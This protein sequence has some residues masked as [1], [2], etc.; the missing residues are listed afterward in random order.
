MTDAPHVRVAILGGGMAGLC[1]AIR[2]KQRGV[3]S[4]ALLEKAGRVGGTWRENTYPGVACDVPSHLYSF[5]FEQNPEWSRVFAPGWE[6]QKYCERCVETYGLASHLRLGTEVRDVRFEDGRW[7]VETSDG[8]TLFADCVVSALGGLHRP[9]R[10]SFPGQASFRGRLFHSAEWDHACDMR[11]KRVGVVGSGASAIQIVPAIAPDTAEVKQFQRTPGWVVPR[12]DSAIS[13]ATRRRFRDHPWLLRAQR[14]LLY[15]LLEARGRFVVEGSWMNRLVEKQARGH[16]AKQ[17]RDPDTRRSLTPDY[18]LGCKRVLVSDDYY[19]S[20]N[21]DN[22][23]LVTS[24]IEGFEPEG[25]RSADGALHRLDA[26]VT[27]TGFRPFDVS[28]EVSVRGRAGDT[29]K[30][31]WGGHIEAH[32]TVMVPG[33]PN[34]FFFARPEQWPRAQLGD[35][36]DRNTGELRAALPRRPRRARA[37]VDGAPRRSQRGVQPGFAAGHAAHRVLGRVR[38]VVHR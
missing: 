28:E 13:A 5:S 20:L 31:T 35:L 15:S 36:D 1:M 25:I 18:A 34:F 6:I 7:R 24:P 26:I 29:L 38:F 2:L 37:A 23:E 32:R 4:F 8:F 17:V 12:F 3:K 27:A 10:P 19:P 30:D 14:W 22:V 33:F 16:L 9:N 21:R 11:G